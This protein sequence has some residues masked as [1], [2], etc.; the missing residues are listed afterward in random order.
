MKQNLISD[1]HAITRVNTKLFSKLLS[2]C[3]SLICDSINE[4]DVS[5]EDIL[6]LDIGIGTIS[7]ILQEDCLSYDFY[8]SESLKTKL[9]FTLENKIN[10]VIT[11][12]EQNLE[13]KLLATYKDLL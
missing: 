5:G 7:F 6:E 11:T 3:E 4:L 13:Q 9:V 8:P 10:P 12:A 1:L 2:N